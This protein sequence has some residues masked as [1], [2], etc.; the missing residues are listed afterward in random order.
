M[1]EQASPDPVSL[2]PAALEQGATRLFA[3]SF[4]AQPDGVWLAPGRANL[5]GEHTDYN[6]GFALPF[7][8]SAG[9]C[10]AAADPASEAAMRTGRA[11]GSLAPGRGNAR[12]PGHQLAGQCEHAD[13]AKI[14]Q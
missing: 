7:A 9:V 13:R 8:I 12:E 3:E 2:D 1:P 6:D 14:S 5:I 10:V 11:P 4:G